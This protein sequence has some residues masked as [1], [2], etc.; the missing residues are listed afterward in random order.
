MIDRLF[1]D[2]SRNPPVASVECTSIRLNY[3]LVRGSDLIGVMTEDAAT[4]YARQHKLSILPIELGDRLPA[5]GVMMRPRRVTHATALF[6]RVL[7]ESC[8]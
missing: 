1:L 7:R 8:A 4:G 5:V 6:L 2:A 3:E